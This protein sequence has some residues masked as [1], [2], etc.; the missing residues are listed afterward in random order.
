MMYLH[1]WVDVSYDGSLFVTLWTFYRMYSIQMP[2]THYKIKNLT[3]SLGIKIS[4]LN[5]NIY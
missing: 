3:K 4:N 5:K 2:Q 1:S